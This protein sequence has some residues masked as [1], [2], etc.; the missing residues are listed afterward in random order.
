MWFPK[1]GLSRSLLCCCFP[2]PA[3]GAFIALDL[4]LAW[5]LAIRPLAITGVD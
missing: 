4:M 2:L 3:H 5:R 1:F